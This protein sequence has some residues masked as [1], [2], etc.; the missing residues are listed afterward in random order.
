LLS[1]SF[2]YRFSLKPYSKFQLVAAASR[3]FAGGSG[4][5]GGAPMQNF[6]WWRRLLKLGGGV[7]GETSGSIVSMR[8][9][10]MP[11]SSHSTLHLAAGTKDA[12]SNQLLKAVSPFYNIVANGRLRASFS[13]HDSMPTETTPLLLLV[14]AR[15]MVR[16]TP[17]KF[18]EEEKRAQEEITCY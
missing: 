6:R 17:V 3:Q 7:A 2:I 18:D 11:L 1:T 10:A 4:G 9:L 12:A 8:T 5:C 13:G 16:T 14:L 15:A